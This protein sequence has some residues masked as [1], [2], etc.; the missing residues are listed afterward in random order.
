V[1]LYHFGLEAFSGGFA[2]VDVFFVISGYVISAGLID[3]IA[4]GSFTFA[5]FYQR[6]VRRIAPA[7]V[8]TCLFTSV[9]AWWLLLPPDL[10]DYS[11]SLIATLL[12]VSNFYFWRH[13]GYFA[14]QSQ[15]QPLLHCWSLAV[16]E[17]FYLFMPMAMALA[18]PW[19]RGKWLRFMV[20]VWLVS[21][22][23]CI[24]AV[25]VGPTSGFYLLPS[26]TWEL[27]T[28]AII[29]ALASQRGEATVSRGLREAAAI[30][31]LLLVVAG[32]ALLD[33]TMAFPAWNA[34]LPCLGTGLIIWAGI[35]NDRLP[36]INR[37]LCWGPL[38]A[39]GTISYS[40]YLVHWP[41]AAFYHYRMMASPT[42][43]AA[44]IMLITTIALAALMYRLI[45]QP[46]RTKSFGGE[47]KLI[48]AGA[49]TLAGLLLFGGV[50]VQQDGFPNRYPG[51]EPGT[52]S[53]AGW[54]GPHC[55]NED[56]TRPIDW[57]PRGCTRVHGG[58]DRILL[59]GDSYAAHYTTGLVLDAPAIRAD[60]M[61]YS[62]PGCPPILA[63]DSFS[64]VGC[65]Q[66]NR[67]V[68]ALIQAE[69]IGT[70]VLAA[71]WTE[72]PRRTLLRLHET[73]A[74]LRARGT[75]VVVIGQ[76]PEFVADPHRI[77]WISGQTH[78]P[79]G[80]WRASFDPA[81]NRVL[82]A[83][84]NAGDGRFVDPM[85]SLCPDGQCVYRRGKTWLYRDFGHFSDE[86]SLQAVRLY[87][88]TG[89]LAGKPE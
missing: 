13:S 60:V 74:M 85:A 23:I 53:H 79:N 77:D 33:E 76:S 14:P 18:A 88:P 7:L 17:Q 36:V 40:M 49:A 82:A 65:A 87:F 72:V 50:V 83:Q 35:G 46:I 89:A 26:R 31:G 27:M 21:F 64:R 54:G 78:Q 9:A 57:D 2:G 6:R 69:R 42:L 52:T 44:A 3:G 38:T 62:M 81:I 8:V 32:Y 51:F 37:M 43:L 71:R 70:V 84:T 68:P 59:W 28:G 75:Q 80:L 47:R 15:S 4:A 63:F 29:A 58:G 12:S 66:S 41:I 55:F 30:V 10:A 56:V 22:A 86:G 16:E 73:V 5:G 61:Q 48:A 19:L 1:V 20:P 67:R 34:L 39:I 45:E 24:A 25:F 11:S